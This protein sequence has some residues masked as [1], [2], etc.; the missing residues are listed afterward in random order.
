MSGTDHTL[1]VDFGN[2]NTFV[3][4][5]EEAKFLE[6]AYAILCIGSDPQKHVTCRILYHACSR[7]TNQLFICTTHEN[8][9][10]MAAR[11]LDVES[12]G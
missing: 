8:F 1:C 10:Y 3:F 7:A 6:H 4:C 2:G 11:S 5:D 12:N 9:N